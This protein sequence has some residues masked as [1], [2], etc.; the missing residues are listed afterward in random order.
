LDRMCEDLFKCLRLLCEEE[1]ERESERR[2]VIY[3]KGCEGK[4]VG[5]DIRILYLHLGILDLG[6]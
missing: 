1:K 5:V 6:P 2:V 3:K 4:N